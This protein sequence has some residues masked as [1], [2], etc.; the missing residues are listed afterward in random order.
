MFAASI[1]LGTWNADGAFG[2]LSVSVEDGW[3]SIGLNLIAEAGLAVGAGV[4]ALT[5]TPGAS[6]NLTSSPSPPYVRAGFSM[7]R[8]ENLG[9]HVGGG[10]KTASIGSGLRVEARVHV[11]PGSEDTDFVLE[12]LFTYQ[13]PF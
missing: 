5:L 9:F 11:F 2:H 12:G 6:L 7:F 1:G 3:S 10:F 13:V 8:T 4:G